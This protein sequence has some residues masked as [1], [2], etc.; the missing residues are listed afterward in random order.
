MALWSVNE[1]LGSQMLH[2]SPE[3]HVVKEREPFSTPT[4]HIL[5]NLFIRACNCTDDAPHK[6][7]YKH[8]KN[9]LWKLLLVRFN[10]QKVLKIFAL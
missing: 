7:L 1:H 9:I 4:P 10:N 8:S 2:I 6:L 3:W 5:S